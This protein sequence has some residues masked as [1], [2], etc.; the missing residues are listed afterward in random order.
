MIDANDLHEFITNDWN[1]QL[2]KIMSVINF[3]SPLDA[4]R[5]L[6]DIITESKYV[7][8]VHATNMIYE[9]A[10]RGHDVLHMDWK[11][12]NHIYNYR[13]PVRD[14]LGYSDEKLSICVDDV[15]Y[16]VNFIS[17]RESRLNCA[18]VIIGFPQYR[19]CSVMSAL[20]TLI[21][22]IFLMYSKD[23]RSAYAST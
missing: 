4:E 22:W 7:S 13:L 10:I 11:A 23:W 16:K 8:Y 3:D 15:I 20:N 12:I 21:H 9:L 1:K 18:I 14:R 19:V 5:F 2:I 17:R 6:T